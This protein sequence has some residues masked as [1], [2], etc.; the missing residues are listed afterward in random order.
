[1][2]SLLNYI[3]HRRAMR[4]VTTYYLLLTTSGRRATLKL[5]GDSSR[6]WRDCR[7]EACLA[8]RVRST[9]IADIAI[10]HSKTSLSVIAG[11][12]CLAPT[13]PCG[14]KALPYFLCILTRH[15]SLVT[16]YFLLELLLF[17]A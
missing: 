13:K 15:S 8:R 9:R 5:E 17:H 12:A 3:D 16:S 14:S 11:E 4:L 10:I 6:L 1:M 7:G 2:G